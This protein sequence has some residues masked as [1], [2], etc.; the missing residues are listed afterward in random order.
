M[1]GVQ[2]CALPIFGSYAALVFQ[3]PLMLEFVK[4]LSDI[5]VCGEG[6]GCDE[7]LFVSLY[8]GVCVF[9]VVSVSTGVCV[10]FASTDPVVCENVCVVDVTVK[11]G[12]V[13][14]W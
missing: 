5:E 7:F 2:T 12:S 4:T 9:L 8:A 14:K 11:T 13:V 10:R 1:T 3:S 6:E